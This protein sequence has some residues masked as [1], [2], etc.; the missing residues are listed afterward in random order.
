IQMGIPT[1]AAH[2]FVLYYAIL[3]E[4]TPP[5]CLS[6]Y[7]GASI[8]G[9]NA[10]QTG[11]RAFRLG[12]V[13]Y[14][15]PFMFV[16]QPSLLLIGDTATVITSIITAVIGVVSL[17][18]GMQGYFLADC[19]ALERCMLLG[20]GVA[21]LYPGLTTDAAGIGLIAAAAAMQFPR[22]RRTGTTTA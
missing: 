21:L 2:L 12:I 13:A 3:S 6:A 1:I 8:A 16:F 5:V 11:W 22:Y 19:S 15:I 14:I 18:G 4:I 7:A 20:A 17:A 10:M 9:A